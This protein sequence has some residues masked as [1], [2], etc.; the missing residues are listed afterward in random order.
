M[1]DALL[2]LGLSV[3]WALSSGSGGVIAC[4]YSRSLGHSVRPVIK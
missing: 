4:N 1:R 2:D 3:K